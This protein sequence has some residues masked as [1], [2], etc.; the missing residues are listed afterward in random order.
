VLYDR[1]DVHEGIRA[2]VIDRD[3]VPT[4]V[5]SSMDAVSSKRVDAY[6]PSRFT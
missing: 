5:P 3:H 2:M 4:W 6:F 1:H